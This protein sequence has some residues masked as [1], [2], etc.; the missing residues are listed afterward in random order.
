MKKFLALVMAMLMI[1]AMGTVAFA[2]EVEEDASPE[3]PTTTVLT[4]MST[5]TLTKE[6][7]LIGNGTSPAEIFCFSTLTCTGVKDVASGV[8][9]KNAPVPTIGSASFRTGAAGDATDGKQTITIT[10]PNYSSVG[11]YTYTF[12]EKDG[13]TAGVTYRSD[14]IKLVVYVIE[15]NG[16][17]R[18]AAVHTEK[19]GKKS[20]T[21]ENTYSAGSLA[22]TKKVTGDFGDTTKEFTVK[23]TFT[24]PSGDTVKEAISYTD[25][26][27]AKTIDA[28]WNGSKN[29]EITLKN[30]ETVTFT[31]IP[32]GVTYKVD[33]NDYSDEGYTVNYDKNQSGTINSISVSTTITNNKGGTI[34]TGMFLDNAPYMMIMALVVLAGAAMLLK[35]RAY[36]D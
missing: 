5:V 25:D 8:T 6:Y 29:V 13:G 26:D 22:V 4:D 18:V 32:Y 10:L 23:V 24:A 35:K 2:D 11:V 21:F 27:A 16:K 19:E 1:L 7:K 12:T 3:Q 34:D 36:N 14:T 15:R 31:N 28:N 17:T 30:G 9:T 33:E 20:G